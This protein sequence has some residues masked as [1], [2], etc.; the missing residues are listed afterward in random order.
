MSDE[1]DNFRKHILGIFQLFT[2]ALALI[3]LA[4]VYYYSQQEK[5][6]G[7]NEVRIEG[8]GRDSERAAE[9]LSR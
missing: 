1:D 9:D 5:I 8:R 6:C 7:K 2:F 4:E 3:L